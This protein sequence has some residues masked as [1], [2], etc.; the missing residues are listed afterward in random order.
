MLIVHALKRAFEERLIDDLPS[1]G[2][3]FAEGLDLPVDD[4]AVDSRV[5]EA[6]LAVLPLSSWYANGPA[7]AA[8]SRSGLRNRRCP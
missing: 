6:G 4:I 8:R 1:I 2:V 7:N 5:R 3:R